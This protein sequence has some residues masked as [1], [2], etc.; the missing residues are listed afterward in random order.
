MIPVELLP[1]VSLYSG[2]LG[3]LNSGRVGEPNGKLEGVVASG[4]MVCKEMPPLVGTVLELTE[5]SWCCIP[6]SFCM[7]C[8]EVVLDCCGIL[9]G[10]EEEEEDVEVEVE[11]K[12][13]GGGGGGS[14]RVGDG[15]MLL[16]VVVFKR[17]VNVGLS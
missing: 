1:P 8:D 9:K 10:D 2:I 17:D 5:W 15:A 7:S 16:L 12:G 13:Y 6:S 3:G 4:S 11:V 14:I